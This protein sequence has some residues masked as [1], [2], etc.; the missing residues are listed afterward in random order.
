LTKPNREFFQNATRRLIFVP[1]PKSPAEPE[2]LSQSL[3][4]HR[5]DSQDTYDDD[6]DDDDDDEI[7]EGAWYHVK[8]CLWNGPRYFRVN[9]SLSSLYPGN[10]RLFKDVLNVSEVAISHFL[11]EARSFT[12]ND[13]L[14]HMSRIL[15]AMDKFISKNG[16]EYQDRREL[17]SLHIWPVSCQNWKPGRQLR[18][19]AQLDEW[20]IADR[21]YWR[22]LFGK[23]VPI[24]DFDFDDQFWM[25]NIFK[26]L[27]LRRCFITRASKTVPR[28]E[29]R[30]ELSAHYTDLFRS[31][32]RFMAR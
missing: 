28:F 11:A 31:K 23:V 32:Y 26:Q 3:Q 19:A 5:V 17:K 16:I 10:K 15:M 18:S 22:D 9:M 2:P 6:D 12:L 20:F 8:R 1:T 14:K 21:S 13:P 7:T 4:Y 25:R 30:V 29:G 27:G 24:L